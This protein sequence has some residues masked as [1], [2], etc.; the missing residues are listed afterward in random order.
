MCVCA[1][2]ATATGTNSYKKSYIWDYFIELIKCRETKSYK[3]YLSILRDFVNT[4]VAITQK[5]FVRATEF[6]KYQFWP[7][8]Y[9]EYNW[10][11]QNRK[12]S[13]NC[14]LAFGF[15]TLRL[16]QNGCHFADDI[17]KYIFLNKNVSIVIKIL[18]KFVPKGPMKIFQHWFR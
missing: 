4:V 9:S 6:Q 3:Q 16:R 2:I 15:N 7:S 11:R 17:F 5:R 13:R 12:F 10:V 18:L 14:H 8:N 1:S